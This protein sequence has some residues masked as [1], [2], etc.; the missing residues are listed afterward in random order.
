MVA[1][2]RTKVVGLGES[3]LRLS[4]PGYE[5]LEQAR[6]LTVEVG[7]AE[8][9]ALIGMAALGLDAV[10]LTRLPDSALGRR[11]AAHA[12]AHGVTSIVDW[13][14]V[15]VRLCTSWSTAPPPGLP[16]CSMT[17]AGRR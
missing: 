17:A 9:N 15:A 8:M 5:R 10:W 14:Q 1:A 13:D 2:R 6:G 3:L 7:G 11:I 16:R 12:A 4:A